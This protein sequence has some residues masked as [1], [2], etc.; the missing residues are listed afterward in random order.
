MYRKMYNG[1]V[2]L[3]HSGCNVCACAQCPYVIS[4]NLRAGVLHSATPF[5]QLRSESQDDSLPHSFMDLVSVLIDIYGVLIPHYV[6]CLLYL[7]C[8]LYLHTVYSLERPVAV[9]HTGLQIRSVPQRTRCALQWIPT[10]L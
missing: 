10:A 7:L 1:R 8:S 9:F 2:S 5:V 3:G 4:C 6:A